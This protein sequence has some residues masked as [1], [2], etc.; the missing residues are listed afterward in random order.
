MR[1]S[2]P[3]VVRM[4]NANPHRLAAIA[5]LLLLL[6][7]CGGSGSSTNADASLADAASDARPDAES[8]AADDTDAA[9]VDAVAGGQAPDWVPAEARPLTEWAPLAATWALGVLDDPNADR[10]Y[11]AIENGT[12]EFLGIGRGAFRERWDEAVFREDGRI[13]GVPAQPVYVLAQFSVDAPTNLIVQADPASRVWLAGERRP[14]D[15]YGSGFARLA[16]T[17]EPGEHTLIMQVDG[18]RGAPLVRLWTT[19]D[20]ATLSPADTTSFDWVAGSTDVQYVGMPLLAFGA[21]AT[22]PI[23]TRVLASEWVEAS[24]I[25]F[26]GV[27]AGGAT[28]VPFEVRPARAPGPD[29]ESIEVTL[30]IDAERWDAA[31]TTTVTIPVVTPETTYRRTFRSAIDGSTQYYGVVPPSSYDPSASYGLIL[32]LHGAS[33]EAIGQARAYG[34]K[35][36]AWLVAPTNRRPFGFD[37]EAFGRLDGLEV[38]ADAERTFGTD[39]TRTHVTGHSMGGHGTWQFGT[40]FPG[41]FATVGPSAGWASFYSYT[42]YPRPSGAFARASASSDSHAYRTNLANRAVFIVHGDA[43]DNVPVREATEWFSLLEPLVPD[44]QMH[45]EPGA[46]H[47]WDG[48]RAGGA[49]CVDWPELMTTMEARRLDPTELSF[50][51][52]TPGPAVSPTH[53]YATIDAVETA[54]ADARLVSTADAGAVALTTTNVRR[55]FI[56]AAALRAAGATSLLVDGAPVDLPAGD[57]AQI[58]PDGGKRVGLMG[59]FN[60]AFEQPYCYVY[61][62]AGP[63]GYDHL[64]A[65]LTTTWSIIGNGFAC[66]VTLEA[67]TPWIIDNYQLVYLGVPPELIAWDGDAPF[68]LDEDGIGIGD[69]RFA[70]AAIA[71]VYPSQGKLAALLL[72]DVN[73]DLLYQFTPFQSRLVL[74]DYFVWTDAGGQTAGFFDA[75]WGGP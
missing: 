21:G 27:V 58:G 57:E 64:A 1:G 38:L 9:R 25:V 55:L 40:L 15:P 22:G 69:A 19:P 16:Y 28:N 53:S 14:G 52:L 12:F 75:D 46:G 6:A 43:D 73:P 50:D 42:G 18:R 29:V 26:P 2:E 34:P 45:L 47:W 66:T 10:V 59:P 7:A 41:R 24:A 48:D 8:D 65:Y 72:D 20:E 49:D 71:A 31:Y 3:H 37:W 30:Q 32:S 36:W 60:A 13:D 74:P 44:L 51:F 54:D 23:R 67:L 35:S 61:E 5:A 33:V 63:P 4:R 11:G 17:V 62:A 70:R 68:V 39:P 56:D